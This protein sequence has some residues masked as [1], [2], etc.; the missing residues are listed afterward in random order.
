MMLMQML[1]L[2]LAPVRESGSG[3]EGD[4]K[5]GAVTVRRSGVVR[6]LEIA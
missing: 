6:D 4:R 2:M 1:M 3:V 5:A